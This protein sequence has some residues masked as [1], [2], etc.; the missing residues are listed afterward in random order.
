MAIDF[1][2]TDTLAPCGVIQACL[3]VA[4]AGDADAVQASKGGTPGTTEL[5]CAVA[6]ASSESCLMFELAIADDDS[7]DAGTLS[8]PINV[9]TAQ[10]DVTWE[11]I[12]VCRLNSSCTS[13]ETLGSVTGLAR[14]VSGGGVFT[15]TVSL[16]AA[17]AHD[18]GDVV[19]I[20]LVFANA[21]TMTSRNVAVTPDQTISTPFTSAVPNDGQVTEVGSVRSKLPAEIVES[22][23]VRASVHA[24]VTAT[25]SVRSKIPAEVTAAGSV[26][27]SLV[28]EITEDGSVRIMLPAEIVE[29]GSVRAAV[30]AEVTAQGSARSKVP[31]EVTAVG[32]ARAKAP[33]EVVADASARTKLP[34]IVTAPGSVRSVL[35]IFSDDFNRADELLGAG[36]DWEDV[37]EVVS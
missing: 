28:A 34:A 17:S 25:G 21:H 35:Q 15:E 11:E 14:D 13:Q 16:S 4:P 9:T 23:S 27:A 32:S 6:A 2:Q 36:A 30:H 7:L 3:P 33:A 8:L 29:P 1:V 20:V 37:G 26:R 10:M 31:A 18:A 22:G 24:E 12:Y 19:Y 5:A